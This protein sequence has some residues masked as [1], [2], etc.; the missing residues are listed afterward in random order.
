[1]ETDGHM[2]TVTAAE[3]DT[4]EEQASAERAVVERIQRLLAELH[5]PIPYQGEVEKAME[6]LDRWEDRRL[7]RRLIRD[8]RKK[9]LQLHEGFDVLEDIL[10][11]SARDLDRDTC[12]DHAETLRFL[13]EI[14][15]SA[16]FTL[17]KA[18]EINQ[19]DDNDAY[20]E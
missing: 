20:M 18:A 4:A 13:A 12:C 1:M 16:A 11:S 15:R 5:M 19:P 17:D 9:V 6:S 14:A 2:T 10:Q 7:R 8:M 3:C